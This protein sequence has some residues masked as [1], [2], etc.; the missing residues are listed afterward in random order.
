MG[1]PIERDLI[2]RGLIG[3]V[4]AG[5][6]TGISRRSGSLTTSGQWAAFFIG[7]LATAAGW[8]WAGALIAFFGTAT[9]LTRWR[10]E[11]KARLTER[12]IPHATQRDAMQVLANGSMFTLLAVAAHATGQVRLAAGALGALAAANADTWSTEV[13]TLLGGPP[14]SI[15]SF[16]PLA[17]GLSGGVT[18]I[19][20][21]AGVAGA[22]I[23]AIFGVVFTVADGAG[24]FI[25][26]VAVEA[27]WPA[28]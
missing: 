6:I 24:R 23:I 9:L 19:G 8:V 27:E 26:A 14:R 10:A 17:P 3:A 7:I 5:A 22:L 2:I 28:R 18:T 13:G 11:E 25:L 12:T 1:V 20:S 4:I 21:L 15:L 16:R